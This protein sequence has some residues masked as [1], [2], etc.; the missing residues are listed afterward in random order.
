[1]KDEQQN[2]NG[3][4]KMSIVDHLLNQYQL[5]DDALIMGTKLLSDIYD[6]CKM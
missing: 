5:V 4:E 6:R 3:V 1:M 2:W